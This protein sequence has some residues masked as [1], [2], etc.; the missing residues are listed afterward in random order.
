MKQDVAKFM[1]QGETQPIE[2]PGWLA[3]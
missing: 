3:L 1:R 2:E